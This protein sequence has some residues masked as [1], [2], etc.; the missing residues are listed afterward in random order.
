MA[1]LTIIVRNEIKMA[2]R[3]RSFLVSTIILPLV[4]VIV[5]IYQS[6]KNELNDLSVIDLPTLC[7]FGSILFLWIFMLIYGAQLFN[8]VRFEKSNKL[9]E[10]MT[11]AV[12]PHIFLLGKIL[13]IG[14]LGVL[15]FVIWIILA[16]ICFSVFDSYSVQ[17]T[18]LSTTEIISIITLTI[19]NF[20]GGYLF[21]GTLFVISGSF[22]NIDN[23]NQY[24]MVI[25]T[26][27]LMI[28]LYVSFESLQLGNPQL[29]KFCFYI[30]FTSPMVMLPSF[31]LYNYSIVQVIVSLLIL[32]SSCYLMILI[33]GKIY[34]NTLLSHSN[35]SVFKNIFTHKK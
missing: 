4:F 23:D 13:S 11:L 3:K 9:S 2:L 34:R 20:I 21:Y 12:E 26:F 32:F 22:V 8:S 16:I 15:Q 25:V 17:F 19:F 5:F 29:L 24:Y 35:K 18:E 7:S 31:M 28:A 10:I 6:S 30:P 27:L 14:I 1:K 33:S